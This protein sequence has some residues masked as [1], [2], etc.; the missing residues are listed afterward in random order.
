MKKPSVPKYKIETKITP[1]LPS[2]GQPK[3]II[4]KNNLFAPNTVKK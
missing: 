1:K 2:Q 3:A 4:P